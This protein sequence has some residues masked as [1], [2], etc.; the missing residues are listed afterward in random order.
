MSRI[1]LV[2]G[3][4]YP[5]PMPSVRQIAQYLWTDRYV[6]GQFAISAVVAAFYL[7]PLTSPETLGMF[8][9]FWLCVPF[10]V[11][12][13]M[14]GATGIA[15][16]PSSEQHAWRTAQIGLYVVM[17]LMSGVELVT[18]AH[19]TDPT[20]QVLFMSGYP[21]EELVRQGLSAT[22]VD[23]IQKPFTMDALARRVRRALDTSVTD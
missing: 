11:L 20:L 15:T 13:L 17:P 3:H 9:R 19:A 21:D 6:R 4:R 18:H 12:P 10:M 1:D 8:S 2:Y 14:A 23:F 22:S 16:L 5:S 7:F